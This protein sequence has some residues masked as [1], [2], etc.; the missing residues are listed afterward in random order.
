MQ[1]FAGG[2][3][4]IGRTTLLPQST[5]CVQ[6]VTDMATTPAPSPSAA[7][8]TGS[9]REVLLYLMQQ[10]DGETWECERCGHSEDTATMDSADY[11]RRYLAE[12]PAP[13]AAVGGDV[14]AT[15]SGR[16]LSPEG[17][18]EFYGYLADGVDMLPEDAPLYTTPQDLKLD[19]PAT[20]R[21]T[22]FGVGVKWSTVIERAQ[23]EHEYQKQEKKERKT[24]A[25]PVG[26]F[27]DH[28]SLQVPCRHCGAVGMCPEPL[29]CLT[30]SNAAAPAAQPSAKDGV[31]GEV[32]KEWL[33]GK[34]SA[35]DDGNC[36]AT[37]VEASCL[38][39]GQVGVKFTYRADNPDIYVCKACAAARFKPE[40]TT[41][42]GLVDGFR[43][44]V[45]QWRH[46]AQGCGRKD[47][48]V[49]GTW[50]SCAR[51]LE[52]AIGREVGG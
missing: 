8:L 34:L 43:S 30:A 7:Y 37:S 41:A 42:A 1:S 9:D 51:E 32:T 24:P 2:W 31:R 18:R 39:C 44:L 6:G 47:S 5:A 49:A 29:K 15:F 35:C 19:R 36:A 28:P 45:T 46:N 4:A 38:L 14:V 23:R 21:S 10:F 26:G 3:A 25:A 48:H 17:T 22:T 12:H 13:A 27:V 33:E 50:R 40:A 11:L 52:A 16:R 20:I